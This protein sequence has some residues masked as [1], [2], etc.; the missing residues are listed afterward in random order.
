M[1]KRAITLVYHDVIK[2]TDADY[3]G[4]SG[5]NPA[6]YKITV[7]EFDKHLNAIEQAVKTDIVNEVNLDDQ[8]LA[9]T[10]VLLSFDDGGVSSYDHIAPM[11]E[12]RGWR[13]VFFVTTDRIDTSAFLTRQQI[14]ELRQRGHVIGSHSCSHPR[15]ISDCT[16]VQLLDEWGRSLKVLS[17][18]TGEAIT[19]ASIPGGFYSR[20]IASAAAQSG[21]CQL[22]TSEPMQKIHEVQGCSVLGRYSVKRGDDASVA[23]ELVAGRFNRCMGQYAYWNVKKVAKIVAGP[24]YARLRTFLLSRR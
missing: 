1:T 15:R 20:Q 12:Q 13:G 6:E 7:D 17:D 11:L 4:F 23:A 10:P 19:V 24:L 3:S 5:K 9:D 18:I 8:E 22:F 14:K 2:G 21:V 16:Y